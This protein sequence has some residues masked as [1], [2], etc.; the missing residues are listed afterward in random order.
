VYI[1]SSEIDV[2][3]EDDKLGLLNATFFTA[4]TADHLETVIL[5]G[6]IS[7]DRLR[8]VQGFQDCGIVHRTL[9]DESSI[10][11]IGALLAK[12]LEQSTTDFGSASEPQAPGDEQ[13]QVLES[14]GDAASQ[15]VLEIGAG[16]SIR[17][18]A[19][20]VYKVEIH[21]K[22][23]QGITQ[24]ESLNDVN[25]LFRWE[26]LH[27]SYGQLYGSWD[28]DLASSLEKGAYSA[29]GNLKVNVLGASQEQRDQYFNDQIINF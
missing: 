11:D 3:G 29:G 28:I 22:Y 5:K 13:Y 17:S 2:D 6:R 21:C 15:A 7:E 4:P 20:H 19:L 8:N 23:A 26:K 16:R 10:N 14:A 12:H 27:P 24:S 1:T 18:V 9:K 25:L